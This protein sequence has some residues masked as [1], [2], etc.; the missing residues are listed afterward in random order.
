MTRRIL[1]NKLA[2]LAAMAVLASS[3]TA[4]GKN[5]TVEMR[6]REPEDDTPIFKNANSRH[7]FGRGKRGGNGK[8]RKWWNN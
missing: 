3:G 6:R 7:D 1:T 5:S 8:G 2:A 4:A